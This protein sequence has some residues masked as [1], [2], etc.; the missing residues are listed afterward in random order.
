MKIVLSANTGWYLWNFRLGLAK[1]LVNDGHDVT[2]IA[3]RDKFTDKL[4]LEGCHVIHVKVSAK[5]K[6]I[7][8]ELWTV[9][10]YAYQLGKLRPAVYLGFTIKP[11][12]Y[13]GI[14]AKLVG[15]ASIA[16]IT[17]LGT[18]FIKESATTR[19]VQVL[20]RYVLRNSFKV[21]FQNNADM[22][23]FL[24]RGLLQ[25]GNALRIS[26]SGV[27]LQKFP[28]TAPPLRAPEVGL[29]FVTLARLLR[30]KGINELVDAAGLVKKKFPNTEFL[31]AGPAGTENRTSISMA[32][33]KKWSTEGIVKYLGPVDDVVSLIADADC[34][35]L[36]SYRE[37]LSRTLL[38]AAAI[39]RPIIT[40]AVPGCIDVVD[41][42]VTGL[43]CRVRSSKDLAQ[44][45]ETF[46]CLGISEREQM[47][48]AGRRKVEREFSETL[49]LNKYRQVIED[50][51]TEQRWM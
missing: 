11:V 33:I 50:L 35:V 34:V 38:E 7:P 5:G 24:Q 29:K 12:L 45:I 10:C 37:G 2:L 14:A 51:I 26:G 6:I 31:L 17:G 4:E 23:L 44:K 41:D 16:T 1:Q 8:R 18:V 19:L 20:Y 40:T 13:G 3:P 39:G 43:L 28:F 32:E 22:Q 27:N 49:V 46:I 21:L 15:V 25:K 47:G 42:K 36:P 9:L 48:R 30:D